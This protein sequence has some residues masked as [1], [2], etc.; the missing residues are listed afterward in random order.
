V[1]LST[2]DLEGWSLPSGDNEEGVGDLR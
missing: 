2:D 1:R